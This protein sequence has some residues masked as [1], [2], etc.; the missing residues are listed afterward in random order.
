M[1]SIGPVGSTGGASC[2]CDTIPTSP[3]VEGPWLVAVVA[4]VARHTPDIFEAQIAA[5]LN[6][7]DAH[8]VF[9]EVYAEAKRAGIQHVQFATTRMEAR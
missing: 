9:A 1:G 6:R 5:L 7:P 8:G 4:M 2:S 3:G